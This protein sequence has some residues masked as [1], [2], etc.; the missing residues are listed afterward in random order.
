MMN[1][2]EPK[3][4][5]AGHPSCP[6]AISEIQHQMKMCSKDTPISLIFPPVTPEFE[7]DLES[8]LQEAEAFAD[9][10]M[11]AND[12][13]TLSR[14][15]KWKKERYPGAR[16]IMGILLNTQ[17]SDPVIRL[18]TEP[19][20][21]RTVMIGPKAVLMQ[22]S[23]PAETL[24]RHWEE[25]SGFHMTA[26]LRSMGVDEME[27]GLQPLKIDHETDHLPVRPVP[28]GVLTVRPCRGDCGKCSGKELLRAGIPVYFDRNLAVYREAII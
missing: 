15:C 6:K 17:E 24:I 28:Y 2:N 20:A 3:K 14:T 23:P 7:R 4:K 18:F 22:W 21:D 11:T 13:G 5:T 25:P 26:L 8:I 27:T 10:E 19:Q 12:W 9:V 16:I 1:G